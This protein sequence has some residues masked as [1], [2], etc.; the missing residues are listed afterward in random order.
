MI[1]IG[2]QF[3]SVSDRFLIAIDGLTLVRY[4]GHE[5]DLG[6]DC[7]SDLALTQMGPYAFSQCLE[8]KSIFIPASIEILGQDCFSCCT[9]LSE[10]TFESDSKL[11]QMGISAFVCCSSLK[12]ISIPANV[13]TIAQC[14][15]NQCNS[16]VEVS[17]EPGSKLTQIE[18]MAF[19]DCSSLHSL[20][21]PAQ[22]EIMARGVFVRCTSLCQ[23]TF[24]LL[25]RLKQLELPPSDFGSLS[26]PDSVEIIFGRIGKQEGQHRL[27]HFGRE[28]CLMKLELRH[29]VHLWDW[30]S[31]ATSDSFVNLS[32]E[33]L[34][35]FRCQFEGL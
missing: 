33:V 26:I 5:A 13:E 30:D 29:S 28:S 32:E 6:I 20:V 34:R 12:S 16:L 11:T 27:L 1:G 23:L 7:L 18:E 10:I 2:W 14:C 8:L 35:R 31:D 19:L 24:D 17:V 21:L 3:L 4:F 25:S 9:S 22:L 15:F